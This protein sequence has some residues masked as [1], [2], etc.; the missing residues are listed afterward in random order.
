MYPHRKMTKGLVEDL[1]VNIEC[2]DFIVV[3]N[4]HI[5][6][7]INT[8]TTVSQSLPGRHYPS[9]GPKGLIS[10]GQKPSTPEC[11]FCTAKIQKNQ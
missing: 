2:N 7:V 10:A 5:V 1:A 4:N 8:E 9:T 3:N 6:I 11:M